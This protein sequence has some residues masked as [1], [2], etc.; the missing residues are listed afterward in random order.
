MLRLLGTFLVSALLTALNVAAA[1]TLAE[2]A[3]KPAR[4]RDPYSQHVALAQKAKLVP[5]GRDDLECRAFT[6]T[7]AAKADDRRPLIGP[8]SLRRMALLDHLPASQRER[9]MRCLAF[10][11]W[12]EARS[13]GVRG[14]KAV[15]AVVLNRAND[16]RYPEHPCS[17]IGQPG[18]FEPMMRGSY[19]ATVQAM[20]RKALAPFPRPRS[21]VDAGALQMARLLVWRMAQDDGF[22]DPTAGATHFV[23]PRVLKARGQRMPRW[24]RAY[25]R[26]ARIGDHHFFR[27]PELKVAR[28]P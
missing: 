21:T 17:V 23:A 25:Q 4:G 18:A 10:I 26:T 27:A 12:A 1:P 14:M 22:R 16:P 2:A 9:A 6:G 28:S 3:G 24:T 11:A 5:C 13:E 7:L 15:V 19:R 8:K 20:K